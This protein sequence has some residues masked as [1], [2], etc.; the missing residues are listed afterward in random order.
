MG[1]EQ[2]MKHSTSPLVREVDAQLRKAT[3]EIPLPGLFDEEAYTCFLYQLADS[4]R[5]ISYVTTLSQKNTH[6]SNAHLKSI[7]FNPIKEAIAL[8]NSNELD[9]AIWLI[10]IAICTGKH[11]DNGWELCR[12]I[13]TGLTTSVYWSWQNASREPISLANWIDANAARLKRIS[14]FGN[15]RK[16]ETFNPSNPNRI[17]RTFE[18]YI[19]WALSYQNH[20]GMIRELCVSSRGDNFESVYHSLSSVRRFGRLA[21]FDFLTMLGKLDLA[22]LEPSHAYIQGSSGPAEGVRQLLGVQTSVA[23]PE[24]NRILELLGMFLPYS[25]IMQVLEDAL[26]NWQK[27]PTEYKYFPG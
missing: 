24:A 11:K 19:S 14:P 9:E 8:R 20:A 5:R 25:F 17:S 3:T 15:H 2:H 6:L 22:P 16:F 27:D 18:S 7:Y 13:Y 4:I 23:V 12:Q 1:N 10:F 26:C 21:R